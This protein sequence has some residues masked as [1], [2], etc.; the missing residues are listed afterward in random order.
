MKKPGNASRADFLSVRGFAA[1][2]D[3]ITS[4]EIN[5]L[6]GR[7]RFIGDRTLLEFIYDWLDDVELE[8]MGDL[9]ARQDMLAD[10]ARRGPFSIQ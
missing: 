3:M 7:G 1:V 8:M 4:L 6:S 10:A 5:S 2:R 9:S